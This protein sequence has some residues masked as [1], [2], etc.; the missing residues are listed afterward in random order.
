M[1]FSTASLIPALAAT[2]LAAGAAMAADTTSTMDPVVAKLADSGYSD[3]TV[4]TLGQTYQVRAMIGGETRE[5]I[6]DIQTG[7]ILSDR[8]DTNGDGRMDLVVHDYRK[9]DK[10]HDRADSKDDGSNDRRGNDR[11]G[12][13]D[14]RGSDAGRGDDGGSRDGGSDDGGSDD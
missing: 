5:L 2:L 10:D 6:Y 8:L 3:I 9:D 4:E 11:E 12:K 13:D 1:K 7:R 14:R